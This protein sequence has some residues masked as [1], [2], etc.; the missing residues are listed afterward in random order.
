[1]DY[2]K[3]VRFKEFILFSSDIDDLELET[4]E[5]DNSKQ[6]LLGSGSKYD[7][8]YE[9]NK[10]YLY[11]WVEY[12]VVGTK[13][14]L[15]KEEFLHFGY[16]GRHN[17]GTI[18]F[19]NFVGVSK[20]RYQV[21]NIESEKMSTKEVNEL[22]DVVDKRVKDII[23]LAFSSQAI[24]QAEF[25]KVYGR[26]RNYYIYHKLY[27]IL[28]E[29]KVMSHL[30]RI[31]RFPNRKF[32]KNM[33]TVQISQPQNITEDTI[34]D[35][36]GGISPLTKNVKSFSNIKLSDVIPVTINEYYNNVSIDTN[37]NRFIKFFIKLC[38]RILSKFIDDLRGDKNDNKSK[39]WILIE[40]LNGFRD[41]FQK[42]LN[43]NFFKE[44]SEIN[45]I[46]YSSTILTRQFGYKQIYKEYI[47][48]KQI[49]LNI[50]NTESLVELFENKSIDKLYEYICLF[51]L[52]D[53]LQS[54]YNDQ[55]IGNINISEN[56]T[57]YTVG[58]SE[59]NGGIVF[60][61]SSTENLYESRVLFQHSFTKKNKGSYS[62]E[63]KPDFTVQIMKEDTV[64][65]YHFDS[66]FKLTQDNNSKNDD[67]AKM[68]SYRDGISNTI[69]AFV[70]YPGD[71]SRVYH[72]ENSDLPY[73]GVGSFPLNI[74]KYDEPIHNLLKACLKRESL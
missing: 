49:P 58:L 40:E 33:R 62:V 69:G 14:P 3:A 68:H 60:K 24:A 2:Y 66:K 28:K 7:I 41:G 29:E 56:K 55:P 64:L 38:V 51:R 71:K 30:M 9:N 46:N 74:R 39:N 27:N 19:K 53:I 36:F 52:I 25:K 34:I 54:I 26:Y 65:Y 16:L 61:F 35:I 13:N 70:L 72:S 59:E 48:L 8:R 6:Y 1:M 45:S 15:K 32:Q 17:S 44:I 22:I 57:L 20:F 47:E 73:S 63:F 37:E 42:L 23:S 11:E 31:Q 5:K 18:I 50:F 67:I 43:N 21:F 10:Y 12:S 4:F